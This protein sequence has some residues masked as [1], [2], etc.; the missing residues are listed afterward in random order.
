MG[1]LLGDVCR[2]RLGAL[3]FASQLVEVVLGMVAER[4][5]DRIDLELALTILGDGKDVTGTPMRSMLCLSSL[6]PPFTSMDRTAALFLSE[7]C[8]LPPCQ[9][10][11]TL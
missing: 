4:P 10:R 9:A 5:A 6:W 2:E 1:G 11:W 3:G 7:S 8:L